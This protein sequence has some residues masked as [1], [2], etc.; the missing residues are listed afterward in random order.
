MHNKVNLNKEIIPQLDEINKSI[1]D[2]ICQ[3][4]HNKNKNFFE[5]CYEHFA[6]EITVNN[7]PEASKD[8]KK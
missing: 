1:I 7:L 8:P 6:N 4:I 3:I 2:E 5:E